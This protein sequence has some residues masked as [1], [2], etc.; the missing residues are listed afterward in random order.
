MTPRA[1]EEDTL[2]PRVNADLV[3]RR[4]R[5]TPRQLWASRQQ[6]QS[7][8]SQAPSETAPEAPEESA[9][10]DEAP[11]APAAFFGEQPDETGRDE[12]AGE[13]ARDQ[14][15][16]AP[17]GPDG[18]QD[19]P[20]AEPAPKPEPKMVDPSM[21]PGAM[22]YP[23]ATHGRPPED[24]EQRPAGATWRS[25]WAQCWCSGSSWPTSTTGSGPSRTA[26]RSLRSSSPGAAPRR[27]APAVPA[28]RAAERLPAAAAAHSMR[29]AT[30]RLAPAGHGGG[31]T[32]G[33]SQPALLP[34][35]GAAAFLRRPVPPRP[36][37]GPP[38]E[39]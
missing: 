1:N 11:S 30:A 4:E 3:H 34:P 7:A 14:A 26:W 17:A 19:T 2:G 35:P 6:A 8:P 5:I 31:G 12:P 27:S 23:Y 21:Q 39:P 15:D 22:R 20:Q 33:L 16:L 32:G 24:D 29:P 9:G 18:P 13:A 28:A 36:R 38:R 37:S 25:C 10:V